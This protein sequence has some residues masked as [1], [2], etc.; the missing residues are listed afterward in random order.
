[1]S[2]RIEVK[3]LDEV[4]RKLSVNLGQALEPAFRAVGEE[5]RAE[6]AQYPGPVSHPIRWASE[7]QRRFYF[8][9]RREA[10]LS[11]GYVRQSDAMSQRLGPSWAVE[12]SPMRAVVGTRV[13]YAPY[14]QAEEMQQ[15]MH[16]ATGWKT[17]KQ[18]AEAVAASGKIE[19]I[20]EQLIR[21]LF[22][23]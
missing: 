12:T 6:I 18:A 17:D 1:M 5:V 16:A 19:R 11:P 9:M 13:G 22:G 21:F 2:Y 10:G 23:G 20:F 4:E 7:R 14:V 8:A 3:G 15:P